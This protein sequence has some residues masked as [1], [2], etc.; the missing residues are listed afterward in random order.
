MP[1]LVDQQDDGLIQLQDETLDTDE[2]PWWDADATYP[3]G[4]GEDEDEDGD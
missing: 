4:G 2:S 3:E 1:D